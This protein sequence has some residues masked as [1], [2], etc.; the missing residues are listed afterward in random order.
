MKEYAIFMAKSD[1]TSNYIFPEFQIPIF[2]KIAGYPE[3]EI[4]FRG[5]MGNYES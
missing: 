4:P 3:V 1:L 5:N 2:I